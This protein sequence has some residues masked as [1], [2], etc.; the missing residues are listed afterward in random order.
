MKN[1]NRGWP[2]DRNSFPPEED[3]NDYVY[4]NGRWEIVLEELTPEE[5]D[6][7]ERAYERSRKRVEW[8]SYHD[9]PCPASELE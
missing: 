7:I 9:E 1:V 4:K 3:D 2:Y 5:E 6:A 8:D